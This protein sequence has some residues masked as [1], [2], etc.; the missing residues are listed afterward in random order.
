MIESINQAI[1]II[2]SNPVFKN[3]DEISL[4]KAVK[5]NFNII[6]YK[7]NEIILS[8]SSSIRQLGII[9]SGSAVVKKGN[10]QMS[11]LKTG[12]IF[13]GVT[14]FSDAAVPMT[15]IYA[16]VECEVMFMSK[17]SF[18]S[19][20]FSDRKVMEDFLHYLTQRIEFLTS[21][22]ESLSAGGCE[23]KLLSYLTLISVDGTAKIASCAELARKL[24]VSRASLYRAISSLSEDGFIYRDKNT[25]KIL[26]QQDDFKKI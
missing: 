22:I 3:V 17:S 24:D 14:L 9:L 20:L 21:R 13:G 12:E 1:I 11:V 26:N 4:L 8:P 16:Q 23:Q 25:F 6:K 10:T 5:E 19:L 15:T 2:E 18:D 7:R